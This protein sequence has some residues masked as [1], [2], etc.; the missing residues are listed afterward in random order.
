MAGSWRCSFLASKLTLK[1][2]LGPISND[3]DRSSFVGRGLIVWLRGFFF[4]CET[5]AGNASEQDRPI[6]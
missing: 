1:K 3:L 2:K 4:P 5:K 6:A